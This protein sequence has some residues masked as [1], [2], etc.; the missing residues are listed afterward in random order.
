MSAEGVEVSIVF[1]PAI[2]ERGKVNKPVPLKAHV[3]ELNHFGVNEI[4][5]SCCTHWS[6]HENA[7]GTPM[8]ANV[9]AISSDDWTN[10]KSKVR[11]AFGFREW[12]GTKY[13]ELDLPNGLIMG[14]ISR[15]PIED[16]PVL[17][18][19]LV[20]KKY[21]AYQTGDSLDCSID[22]NRV[23]IESSPDGTIIGFW[24]G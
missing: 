15:S 21:R 8:I 23:N 24:F 12:V 17:I 3:A 1:K 2:V 16:M 10:L 13:P 22:P 7:D 9:F 5:G 4:Y 6:K 14:P 19:E 20:G 11:G 18:R